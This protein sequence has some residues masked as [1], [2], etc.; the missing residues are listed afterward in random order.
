MPRLQLVNSIVTAHFHNSYREPSFSTSAESQKSRGMTAQ[1]NPNAMPWSAIPFLDSADLEH[2]TVR[3]L[4]RSFLW[5]ANAAAW[6]SMLLAWPGLYWHAHNSV[7]NGVLGSCMCALQIHTHESLLIVY[8]CPIQPCAVNEWQLSFKWGL[9]AHK[10]LLVP[11]VTSWTFKP[12]TELQLVTIYVSKSW[13][14]DR[15]ISLC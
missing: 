13:M 2:Y 15:C 11:M 5:I 1:P 7:A 10:R 8:S 14:V 6:H 3:G 12:I 9:E 4:H